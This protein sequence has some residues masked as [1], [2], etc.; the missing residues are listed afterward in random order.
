[1]KVKAT[2]DLKLTNGAFWRKGEEYTL[3]RLEGRAL[4]SNHSD[5]FTPA[6]DEAKTL[7]AD[8]KTNENLA[9]DMVKVFGAK[10]EKAG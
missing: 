9:A 5:A 4:L 1:M 6:D 3:N 8:L 2:Q 10:P 7:V